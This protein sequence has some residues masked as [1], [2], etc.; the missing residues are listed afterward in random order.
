MNMPWKD[1]FKIESRLDGDEFIIR[2]NAE[3]LI[4]LAQ[5][6]LSLA[7]AQTPTG[8]HFH[9]DESNSLENGSFS[10]VIEKI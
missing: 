7:D 1:N 2:A 9:Y 8:T 4:S 5:Q 6:L 3:G 10:F